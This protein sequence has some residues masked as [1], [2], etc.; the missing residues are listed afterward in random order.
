MMK[1]VTSFK[2]D[3]VQL[4]DALGFN[5][6]QVFRFMQQD[7]AA[8]MIYK[9]RLLN[10]YKGKEI[11]SSVIEVD[12]FEYMVRC[13]H[14]NGVNFGKSSN[15][16]A[17]RT[18]SYKDFAQQQNDIDG[19]FVIDTT[20]FPTVEVYSVESAVVLELFDLGHIDKY[21]KMDYKKFH[22]WYE[23]LTSKVAA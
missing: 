4:A 16:G 9:N 11:S 21:G 2:F 6:A 8:Q 13:L 10:K 7:R 14:S 15:I 22:K 19:Y 5:T 18:F 23:I 20:T 3:H 12:G 17:S 1:Y